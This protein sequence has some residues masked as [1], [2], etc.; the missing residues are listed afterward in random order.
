MKRFVLRIL[1]AIQLTRLTMAFGAIAD[2][3]LV[4]L[5]TRAS[6]EYA[7]LPTSELPLPGVLLVSAVVAVGLFG[8]GGALN[9]LLDARHDSAFSPQRPIPAGRVRAGQAAVVTLGSLMIAMVA[10]AAFGTPGIVLTA[11]AAA[12]ILFY[13]AAAKHIPAIGLVV[14]GLV[15]A[16]HMLI[17]NHQ[18][19]FTL[20]VWLAMTHATAVATVI[21]LLEG[22]RPPLTPRASVAL[23][24]GWI[25][26]SVAILLLGWWQ[27]GEGGFWPRSLTSGGMAW[28]VLAA[29]VFIWL[30]RRKIHGLDRAA[31]A[32]KLHRYGSLWG[33]VYAVS[34]LLAL[35]LPKEAF[36]VAVFAGVGVTSMIA[37]REITALANRPVAFRR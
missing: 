25:S 37:I 15:H 35:D 9:D 24:A 8:F 32:E 31:A 20:P 22:K 18:L 16:V 33:C 14:I 3:W 13:D 7:Y 11:L 10:S 28:P 6:P 17:A 19:T 30:A 27:A 26:W 4:V 5:I 34:W 2:L 36:G 21:Y 12:G 23:V 1:T 29:A